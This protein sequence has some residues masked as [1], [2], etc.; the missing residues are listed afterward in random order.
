M[1]TNTF[2]TMAAAVLTLGSGFAADEK[3]PA[4]ELNS[5]YT[6]PNGATWSQNTL[7]VN[8]DAADDMGI[9]N[10]LD[11]SITFDAD[12]SGV[13]GSKFSKYGSLLSID[14]TNSLEGTADKIDD[15]YGLLFT[16]FNMSSDV[17]AIDFSD[18][19]D[20][21]MSISRDV[22][23]TRESFNGSNS[24]ALVFSG[25]TVSVYM[26]NGEA[27]DEI[28][29]KNWTPT[30]TLPGAG[31][32]ERGYTISFGDK[33]SSGDQVSNIKFYNGNVAENVPEPTTA[34]L[35]LLAL[36]ALVMRRR[37]R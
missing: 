19:V 29:T 11:F 6:A 21:Q 10:Y 36:G 16:D 1:K 13:P 14:A 34:T 31:F 12:I 7:T 26:L 22:T 33:L 32:L 5:E 28:L 3:T 9:D 37:R 15:V 30:G 8:K 24:F 23:V 4:F 35:S 17:Y 18:S 27:Y 2:I 25:I 20:G